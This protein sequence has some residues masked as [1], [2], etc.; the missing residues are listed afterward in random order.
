M[1]QSPKIQATLT[2]LAEFR[3]AYQNFI[4][5]QVSKL[6]DTQKLKAHAYHNGKNMIMT[7]PK[8]ELHKQK[9]LHKNLSGGCTS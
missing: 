1:S 8:R 7:N 3:H 6:N 2:D 4:Q 9:D 5:Q